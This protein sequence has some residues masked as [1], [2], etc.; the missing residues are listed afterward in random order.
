[1]GCG[2]S[3]VLLRISAHAP[4]RATSSARGHVRGKGSQDYQ[5][6]RGLRNNIIIII[7]IIIIYLG[8]VV[9]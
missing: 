2:I 3:G 6:V 4:T 8:P 5:R 7:I 1:M 9:T